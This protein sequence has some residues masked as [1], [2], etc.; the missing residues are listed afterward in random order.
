[1]DAKKKDDNQPL[2][3]E[4]PGGY[5]IHGRLTSQI[6]QL[7]QSLRDL[8]TA[9]KNAEDTIVTVSREEEELNDDLPRWGTDV[10]AV[11]EVSEGLQQRLDKATTQLNAV[12][13]AVIQ[14]GRQYDGDMALLQADAEKRAGG[15]P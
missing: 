3:V 4:V 2:K 7:E 5:F 14:M 1:M 13:E 9:K 12:W 8:A 15:R 10:A 6:G 11:S